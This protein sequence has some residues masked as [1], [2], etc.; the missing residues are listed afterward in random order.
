MTPD[1]RRRL[2]KRCFASALQAVR[3]ETVL[4]QG[5]RVDAQGVHFVRGA[6]RATVSHPDRAAGGRLR[7]LAIGKA[8]ARFA[9]AFVAAAPN[10]IDEGIVVVK[11]GHI[12][13][14]PG[15]RVIE[16]AHPVP[17]ARS[18][19][20]GEAVLRFAA[21]ARAVDRHVVLLSGGASA[22]AVAPI[23]GVSLAD[24]IALTRSLLQSGATIATINAERSKR[25]R[26]KGGK[27]AALLGSSASM[28]LAISDVEGDDPAVIASGPMSAPNAP[29]PKVSYALIATPDDALTAFAATA[30]QAGC[31]VLVLGRTFYGDVGDAVARLLA[32]RPASSPTQPLMVLAAG[33]PTVRVQGDGRG[34]RCLEFALRI[35]R[36]LRD[37]T[38]VTVLAAGTDGTDGPTDATGAIIDGGT[39]SRMQGAGIDPERALARNDAYPALC[40]SGDA[41]FTGPTGT[42]V[43]DLYAMLIAPEPALVR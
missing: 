10:T 11:E 31:K 41:Y 8:A 22:L 30:T 16:A 36:E 13:Q 15:C 7:L 35:A 23:E 24:K 4:A 26:L 29:D 2:L 42:N 43:A 33:E 1:A 25:S 32:S 9:A 12:E 18:L 14:V 37:E 40:A 20:A 34:G 28:V 6:Q 17:D 3:P 21:A 19:A 27:L 38:T 39:W 5:L